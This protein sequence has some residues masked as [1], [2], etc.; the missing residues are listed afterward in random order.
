MPTREQCSS[1]STLLSIATCHT[2][3]AMTP[4]HPLRIPMLN[5]HDPAKMHI[6]DTA[7]GGINRGASN[8]GISPAVADQHRE[9][10]AGNVS[11]QIPSAVE[12]RGRHIS[13]APP[14]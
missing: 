12:R 1:S 3:I 2:A 5:S 10:D 9:D 11:I 13:V 14:V 4:R 8:A 6:Q 7:L